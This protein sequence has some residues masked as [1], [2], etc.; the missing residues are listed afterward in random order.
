MKHTPS[1]PLCL[2]R[3]G[4]WL[5]MAVCALFFTATVL[6]TPKACAEGFALYEW[7]ARGIAL[8]GSTMAR[9]PDPSAVAY[10]PAQ[11]TR[12]PGVQLMG[13][14]SFV[15]PH[16]KVT[17]Y[18][19][20]KTI[21]DTVGTRTWY[22]PHGYYTHELNDRWTFGMGLFSRFG[23]GFKYDN[24]WAGRFNARS[25]SLQT[26]SLS[27]VMAFKATDKLSLAAGVDIMYVTLDIAKNSRFAKGP[28][29]GE[30]QSQVTGADGY[31]FGGV[32][33]AHYQFNENWAAGI[34]YR[35]QA[36]IRARGEN[37]FKLV[38]INN[39]AAADQ[40]KASAFPDSGARG[41]VIL[42]DSLAFGLAWMPTEKFSLEAGATWTRW[43]TFRTLRIHLGDPMK[44]LDG[45]PM[46]A[47]SKK[48]W[49]DSWR[50]NVGAE[51]DVTDWLALRL[52]YVYDQSPMT[53]SWADYLV[54]TNGRHIYS[55]GAGVKYDNWTFDAAYGYV[56]IDGRR[57]Q[58]KND[59]SNGYHGVLDSKT[60][61]GMSHIMS[62]S[63][64]YQ[65]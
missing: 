28:I 39:P 40:V 53:S 36:R 56:D 20:G 44:G 2:H 33:S 51:Y 10:N 17:S 5:S 47:E 18:D 65:F 4:L 34:N 32:F 31:A 30:V 13:G 11:I 62:F 61:G 38:S 60:H 43:S 64:G 50:V 8:G 59:A 23:L 14:M 3:L 22:I 58:K 63:V 25:V 24:D 35:T 26:V 54:P 29:N 15:T 12:L 48:Q 52:G 16:G 9:R 46:V 1:I 37:E 45:G 6:P 41:T 21:T 19:G 57:Y 49:S 7:S 27:P 42:P 55:A